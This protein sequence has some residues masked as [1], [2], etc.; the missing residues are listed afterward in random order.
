MCEEHARRTVE[1]CPRRDFIDAIK[2][3]HP[4]SR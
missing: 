2:T 4:R 1:N 3:R